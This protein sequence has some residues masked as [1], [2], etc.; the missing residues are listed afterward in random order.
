[1]IDP[2]ARSRHMKFRANAVQP[3]KV[4][5]ECRKCHNMTPA[6]KNGQ[7]QKYVIC[8]GC[9]EEE[10]REYSLALLAA[11]RQSRNRANR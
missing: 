1:M 9:K 3:H 10:D 11:N 4:E 8:G 7:I 6:L 5:R 2:E